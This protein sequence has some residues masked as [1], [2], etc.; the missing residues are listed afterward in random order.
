MNVVKASRTANSFP[1]IAEQFQSAGKMTHLSWV[2]PNAP[3][4]A[5]AGTTAWFEPSSLSAIPVGHSTNEQSNHVSSDEDEDEDQEGI[6]KSAK[7]LCDLISEE[8]AR[9][10]NAK[11]IVLGGF[12]QGCCV[13]L[14]AGLGSAYGGR[15]AGVVGLSGGL[16]HGKKIMREREGFVSVAGE[17]HDKMQVF[18]G[19]G[20]K[21]MLVPMRV[22]RDTKESV[23]KQVGADAVVAKVYEGMGHQTCGPE[24]RDVCEFLE[25]ILPA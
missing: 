24:L 3:Y 7:Y 12:S 11:R 14:I 15:I 17:G 19:H 23:E 13:S 22:F 4:S 18:L 16:P 21:D 5:D 8:V 20:T 10:V 2:F 9:G 25:R 6:L 1:D